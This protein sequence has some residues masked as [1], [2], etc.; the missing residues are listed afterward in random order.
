MH[1][2]LS[3]NG[4]PS[5]RAPV[6]PRLLFFF[7]H[8]ILLYFSPLSLS[9]TISPSLTFPSPLMF[10]LSPFSSHPAPHR[11]PTHTEST[12]SVGV[13]SHLLPPE[14]SWHTACTE[15]LS[16]E[17]MKR[18]A[19]YEHTSPF[20]AVSEHLGS[21]ITELLQCVRIYTWT[22]TYLRAPKR[23]CF[24]HTFLL[25]IM[26]HCIMWGALRVYVWLFLQ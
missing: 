11:T 9:F 5:V 25:I 23:A 19:L 13:S 24:Y 16:R 26:T 6:S 10:S 15:R 4:N 20:L 22:S 1:C 2:N 8:L 3:L 17:P 18:T 14:A 12:G 7:F 21:W